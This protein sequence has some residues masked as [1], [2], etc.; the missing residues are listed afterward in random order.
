MS[1]SSTGYVILIFCLNTLTHTQLS[2]GQ[3]VCLDEQKWV[4]HILVHK[5]SDTYMHAMCDTTGYKVHLLEF[6]IL[7]MQ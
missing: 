3:G 4:T 1:Q 5:R 6:N 7:I 2:N